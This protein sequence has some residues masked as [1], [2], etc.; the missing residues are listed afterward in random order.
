[1]TSKYIENEFNVLSFAL[2]MSCAL[3]HSFIWKKLLRNQKISEKIIGI[4]GPY[5]I[6]CGN[7]RYYWQTRRTKSRNRQSISEIRWIKFVFIIAIW[8]FTVT[9]H[10]MFCVLLLYIRRGTLASGRTFKRTPLPKELKD[11]KHMKS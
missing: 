7:I 6:S 8:L 11:T 10:L 1:M 9:S 4:I 2:L 5:V 3:A